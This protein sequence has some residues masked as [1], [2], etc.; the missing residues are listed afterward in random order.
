M[1][2]TMFAMLLA[3]AV[4][5]LFGC[6]SNKVKEVDT[7]LESTQNLSGDQ[8]IGVNSD[9]VA[10]I[11]KETAANDKVRVVK[12]E[13]YGAEQ[14]L[15]SEVDQLKECRTYLADTRLGGNAAVDKI[16]AVDGKA[17][18]EWTQKFGMVNGQ[19]KFIET[20]DLL[21]AVSAG[22]A[23]L[24]SLNTLLPVV[25]D[26]RETCEL[27]LGAARVAHGLPAE[28]YTAQGHYGPE[29]SFIVDR[30]AEHNLDDAF[31]IRGAETQV[32]QQPQ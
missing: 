31:R 1:K 16:P 15:H 27:K 21:Q 18:I 14:K 10:I 17:E 22:Q 19:L 7:K 28:K 4:S 30:K 6:S 24:T 9:H 3:T 23:Y 32:A 11:Q 13:I 2:T 12:W 25:V 20:Q 8:T 26:A 29:G 5:T